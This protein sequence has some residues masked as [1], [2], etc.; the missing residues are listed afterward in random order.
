MPLRVLLLSGGAAAAT[1]RHSPPAPPP[2]RPLCCCCPPSFLLPAGPDE[3]DY[4]GELLPYITGEKQAP[5]PTYFIGGWG[6][7]SKQALEALSGV[8]LQPGR[9]ATCGWCCARAAAAL[10]PGQRVRDKRRPPEMCP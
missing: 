9:L 5:L 6:R 1:R 10:A 8:R 3:G 7:G 4:A 2:N